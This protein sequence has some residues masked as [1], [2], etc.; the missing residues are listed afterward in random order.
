MNI[1]YK[2]KKAAAY[3]KHYGPDK[4]A[5]KAIGKLMDRDDYSARCTQLA[6]GEEELFYERGRFFEDRPLISI[7]VPVYNPPK[8]Y[9]KDMLLSVLNQTY[10]NWQL[11]L[12]DAGTNKLRRLVDELADGDERVCYKEID[13][14]GIAGNTN[15]ALRLAQGEYITLL[16]NDDT[17]SPDAL[18]RMVEMINAEKPDCLYSDEDKMDGEGQSFFCP[19]VKPDYNP[20]LLQSNNYICHLFMVKTSLAKEV[21]GFN[22]E[23]DG[24]QDYDFILRC[25]EKSKKVS[26][27]K[28]ILY[29]W[30]THESSTSANPLSKLYAYDAGKKAIEAHLLRTGKSGSVSMLDDLGFYRVNYTH[31]VTK[32]GEDN[33]KMPSVQVVVTGVRSS[34]KAQRYFK[35]LRSN[36]DYDNFKL[37]AMGELDAD[38]I[39]GCECD[40]ICIVYAQT[41][42]ND[43][44]WLSRLVECAVNE[45]ADAVAAKLLVKQA[46]PLCEALSRTFIVY[47]G[48]DYTDAFGRQHSSAGKPEWYK[49]QFNRN[50]LQQNIKS[51]PKN[52][53]LIRREE[54]VR[55]IADKYEVQ[56]GVNYVY[57]PGVELYR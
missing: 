43:S 44:A 46:F 50:I 19:H 15:E 57:E 35:Y 14:A 17:L 56:D 49:G 28:R 1:N 48:D 41:K 27:V 3:I 16:D 12:V 26:H 51:V 47:A 13:N 23:Y 31:A 21:G 53:V 7:L 4:L 8:E 37:C 32:D 6:A 29:H 45:G 42:V 52:A 2:V 18:Y 5:K 34:E 55:L 9:F 40:Y 33:R 38:R 20:V 25:T 11:C 36:T 22:G 54:L 24:A 39:S 10:F 30:R